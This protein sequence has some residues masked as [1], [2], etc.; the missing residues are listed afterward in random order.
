MIFYLYAMFK[1]KFLFYFRFKQIQCVFLFE[2]NQH[3]WIFLCLI[4]SI[5]LALTFCFLNEFLNNHL[6]DT[7]GLF[8]S[9]WELDQWRSF[10][11]EAGAPEVWAQ[12][13]RNPTRLPSGVDTTLIKWQ[14]SFLVDIH[15]Y[16]S[17][18]VYFQ[19]CCANK[20]RWDQNILTCYYHYKLEFL[21]KKLQKK[22]T[23][24]TSADFPKH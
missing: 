13:E 10:L 12:A 6:L 16:F 11:K 18:Y 9:F 4:I 20:D 17:S 5:S 7:F 22:K 14:L 15:K 3:S 2:T 19:A 24:K 8:V 21:H 23:K 1:A